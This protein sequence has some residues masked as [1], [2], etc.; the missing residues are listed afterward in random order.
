MLTAKEVSQRLAT[1]AED[2]AAYLLPNGTKKGNEWCV[3][4]IEGDQGK[5]LKLNLSGFKAGIWCDF[6]TGE[7]GDLIDLWALKRGLNLKF[8]I[9]EA[10]DYLGIKNNA[11][12]DRKEN[13]FI[14]PSD[15]LITNFF[16]NGLVMDYLMQKRSLKKET[17][18]AFKIGQWDKQIIFPYIRDGIV[19]FAKYLHIDRSS[20]GKKTMRVEKGCEPCLFGWH[21]IPDN[22]REIT[23]C[24]GEID[25]MSLYQ[26]GIAALSL[27][28]GAG[29]KK[30]EWIDYDYDRLAVFDK[31]Y[32]CLDN[33]EAGKITT[34][35]LLVRLGQERCV[36][37]NLPMKDANECLHAGM[38]C[39]EIKV[40]FDNAQG[41]DPP[42]MKCAGSIAEK[43]CNWL[44]PEKRECDG[45]RA[46]WSKAKG[47]ILFRPAEFS[48]WTGI[49]GHGKSQ[50][51]GQIILS[52]MSQGAKVFLASLEM[53]D[54]VFLGRLA[55]QASAINNQSKEYTHAISDWFKGKLWYVDVLGAMSLDRLLE[56]FLYGKRRYGIDVFVIDP[57]MMLSGVYEDDLKSQHGAIQ[58][59]VDF[60]NKNRC[61]VHL[62]VHPR[63]GV[64]EKVMPG[65][66]DVKG[67]GTITDAADSCFVIWRNQRKEELVARKS[68]NELL[69]SDD[70]KRL[71]GYDCYW[72]CVKQ[73]QG[74]WQGTIGL[75]FNKDS[76]QYVEFEAD[77]PKKYVNFPAKDGVKERT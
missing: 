55:R 19:I 10:C 60:K 59:I 11:P 53:S 72:S 75:W 77:K 62:I 52:M 7:A 45:Y 29:S 43:L 30:H 74:D 33:D 6:S 31:I 15:K 76:Y 46:P 35:D 57:F 58:K 70:E 9:R 38:T 25:A 67:S 1:R 27:P 54:E 37:V 24:E 22:A 12:I 36:V 13:N 47:K 63:K 64:D 21:L 20:D 17:I 73:R 44:D 65:K 68:N 16:A 40:Y 26:L 5:S 69:S 14:R 71:G 48:V 23:I 51:V 56:L 41:V 39:D 49:N 8:A 4:N 32:L 18:E 66:M 50:F 34:A 61:Q 42:E 3:G 2:V 28:L